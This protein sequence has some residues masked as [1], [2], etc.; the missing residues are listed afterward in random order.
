MNSGT[1]SAAENIP[2]SGKGEMVAAFVGG[3]VT[4]TLST[5]RAHRINGDIDGRVNLMS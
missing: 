1:E 2:P 4:A 5:V 3:L